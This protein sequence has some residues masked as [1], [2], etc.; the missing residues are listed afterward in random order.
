MGLTPLSTLAES[1]TDSPSSALLPLGLGGRIARWVNRPLGTGIRSRYERS[2]FDERHCWIQT[3]THELSL[4][5]V[6]AKS[7]TI[8]HVSPESGCISLQVDTEGKR[9]RAELLAIGQIAD[10]GVPAWEQA[11]AAEGSQQGSNEV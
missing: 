4:P 2:W 3:G 1:W 11:V 10:R 9:R 7:S 6:S 8:V 5:G